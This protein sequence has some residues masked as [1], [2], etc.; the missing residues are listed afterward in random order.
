MFGWSV[1][2]NLTKFVP[3]PQRTKRQY[4]LAKFGAHSRDNA[5]DFLFAFFFRNCFTN[6]A[7][8]TRGKLITVIATNAEYRASMSLLNLI[9]WVTVWHVVFPT[10]VGLT[11]HGN[12]Q[13]IEI[14]A[15]NWRFFLHDCELCFHGHIK[16][17][18][19]LLAI[20][21][22]VSK[23]SPVKPPEISDFTDVFLTWW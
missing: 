17:F 22:N 5:G 21:K 19:N 23:V 2:G 3:P 7:G 6:C 15:I 14:I 8:D 11:R 4:S 12:I 20:K 13:G 16:E 9:G 18:E 10:W 1:V